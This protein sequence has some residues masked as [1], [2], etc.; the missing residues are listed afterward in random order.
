[1]SG[2][3]GIV[4]S[5]ANAQ[6]EQMLEK[7]AH[8]GPKGHKIL[9]LNGVTL[10]MNWTQAQ[11]DHISFMET[12]QMVGDYIGFGHFA[13]AALLKDKL[14][15]SRD[16]LG[17]SPLY[18]GWTKNRALCFASEV[19]AI[20]PVTRT[21]YLLP[22]GT[23]FLHDHSETYYQLSVPPPKPESP[24]YFAHQVRIR[25]AAAVKECISGTV[26]GAWLSGGIDSSALA[27]L[28]Q[29]HVAKLHTFSAGL[30]G[31]PDI[32]YAREV[33]AF[34]KSDHHERIVNLNDIL[35]IL[36]KVIYYLESF[37]ALLVRS[38]ITN[39][40]V[41]GFAADYVEE[42][43]SGEG[44]DELFAG[45]DYLKLI[46]PSKVAHELIEITQRLHNTALQRVDRCA[47]AYGMIAHVP[48]L[49]PGLV[50][51][52]MEIPVEYKIQNKIEKWILR[53]ALVGWLPDKV[54]QRTKAK[55]WEGAG[56][57][58]LLATHANETIPDSD[59][60]RERFLSNGW[61]L[62]SKEELFY[63]RIFREHFGDLDELSWMGRT[64]M[65]PA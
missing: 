3:A 41:A 19:K 57:G 22:P 31:A 14:V 55:F 8:R 65:F 24:E 18:Y 15:L 11:A 33:A 50:D 13:E 53:R 39:Y 20:L 7:I 35:S 38:S 63:Y 43:F 34:I 26:M 64:K 32:E 21:I 44:S 60:K 49:D 52:A 58:N 1:M 48:F 5:N 10:G 40:L 47:S 9:N 59:F 30:P 45:Y 6:V 29:P 37:D 28:A 12:K 42:V 17:L 25:L 36:P 46:K 23:R 51:C 56:V 16:H 62:H 4:Q 2:I 27:T 61:T 54:L